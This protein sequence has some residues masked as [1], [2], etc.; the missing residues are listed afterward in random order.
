MSLQEVNYLK[1]QNSYIFLNSPY[2]KKDSPQ[3]NQDNVIVLD[4]GRHVFSFVNTCFPEA[5]KVA[6]DDDTYF[7]RNEYSCNILDNGVPYKVTFVV[8][9]VSNAEYLDL[10]VEGNTKNGVIHCL[11]KVH[12]QLFS[13]D[14]ETEFIAII[15]YDAVSEYYCNKI[16]P[17]LNKLERNLRK[18]LFSTYIV[19]Y[20]T[21]YY[22]ATISD[23][24][25]TRIKGRIQ[26]KGN[27][28]KKEI[29]RL[30]EFFY[31][32]ELADIQKLLFTP[33][34][35]DV[36]SR[37]QQE[38]L[39]NHS[40]LSELSNEQLRNAFSQFTPKS[41]WERFFSEKIPISD[42]ESTIDEIRQYRNKAA[43]FKFYSKFEYEESKR[44]IN[45]LNNAVIR[46]I[47]ITEEKDF[48]ATN[49]KAMQKAL[50]GLSNTMC[51]FRE[52]LLKTVSDG[53]ISIIE[54]S[55]LSISKTMDEMKKTILGGF[56]P[57]DLSE[58]DE[59]ENFEHD[60]N[61]EQ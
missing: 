59:D 30:Q 8:N 32:L 39:A 2:K 13:T 57:E 55:V 11:E 61:Q 38:F 16:L 44:L 34:W 26:A 7:Y 45:Q 60:E 41:D 27:E 37:S 42:I 48:A 29:K 52:R 6:A 58:F 33:Q 31:S 35:T 36:E 43:H 49:L 21:E 25:Q 1:V 4:V 3:R 15:T 54:T 18:L 47:R 50:E 53:F 23:D 10:T 14:I 22:R 12:S 46:A 51:E 19:N 28:Q 9:Q 20:G 56:E 24:M 40:D 17:K 5:C